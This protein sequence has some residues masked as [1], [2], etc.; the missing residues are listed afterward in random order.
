MILGAATYKLFAA[1]WPETSEQ[2]EFGNRLNGMQKY[3][4]SR[5]LTAAP[6]GKWPAATITADPAVTV[7]ELKHGD[8]KDGVV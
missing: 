1:G 3:V 2:D 8:G 4:A 5:T 7:R 6:W